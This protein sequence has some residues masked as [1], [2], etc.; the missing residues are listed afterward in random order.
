M[1]RKLKLGRWFVPVLP[2]AA[3]RCAGCAARRSTRS[4]T[5]KVR[6]VE[7]ELIGEYGALVNEALERADARTRTRR[8]SSSASCPT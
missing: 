6:R 4:A 1:K 3:R 5:P 7:R 8:P 2:D